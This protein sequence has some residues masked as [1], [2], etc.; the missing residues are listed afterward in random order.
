MQLAPGLFRI[1]T[2]SL[3]ALHSCFDKARTLA[4]VDFQF[5]DVT[6]KAVTDTDDLS[7]F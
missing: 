1:K 6:A 7:H 5:R 3:S 2:I 4:K